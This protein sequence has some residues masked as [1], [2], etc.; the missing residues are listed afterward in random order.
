MMLVPSGLHLQLYE[1][2]KLLMEDP[3][4]KYFPKFANA[5]VAVPDD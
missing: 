3:L 2:G 5:Q 4:S 1:Q